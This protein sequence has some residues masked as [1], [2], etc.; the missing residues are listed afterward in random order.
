[1][2]AILRTILDAARRGALWENV[3][4]SFRIPNT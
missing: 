3:L 4:E 1:M 2:H